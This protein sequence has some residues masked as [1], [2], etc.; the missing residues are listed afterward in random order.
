MNLPTQPNSYAISLALVGRQLK[1]DPGHGPGEVLYGQE[2][3]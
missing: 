2:I 3:P 1:S